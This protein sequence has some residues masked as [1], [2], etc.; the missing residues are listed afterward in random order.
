MNPI[1]AGWDSRRAGSFQG[2]GGL[3][4]SNDNARGRQGDELAA[5]C[6]T[7]L[8]G[9]D[10]QARVHPAIDLP[11]AWRC[12]PVEEI[13][14]QADH[15]RGQGVREAVQLLHLIGTVLCGTE[16]GAGHAGPAQGGKGVHPAGNH[17]LRSAKRA[18]VLLSDC[19][20]EGCT[21]RS[22][23]LHACMRA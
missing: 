11:R 3:L 12:G 15:G 19:R 13:G 17:F 16:D 8:H 2:G 9:Q 6:E 10:V 18:A 22:V 20:T 7:H 23:S 5:C 14:E 1:L 21:D 4:A